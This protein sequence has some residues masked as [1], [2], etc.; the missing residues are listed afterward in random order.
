M[1]IERKRRLE[2]TVE[3]LRKQHEELLAEMSTEQI[4]RE[5]IESLQSFIGEIGE[6]LIEADEDFKTRQR[7]V[8]ILDLK[9]RLGLEDGQE[10]IEL[11]CILGKKRDTKSEF[12][13]WTIRGKTPLLRFAG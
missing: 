8:K 9:L 13:I 12:A 1:L 10:I 6:G 7:F 11:A 5:Q 2:I 4:T 3:K